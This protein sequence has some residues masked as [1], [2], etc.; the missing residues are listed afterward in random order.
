MK[1]QVCNRNNPF[2]KGRS[3][4]QFSFNFDAAWDVQNTQ[5]KCD[6]L[7]KPNSA[8]LPAKLA[9]VIF[10]ATQKLYHESDDN[11]IDFINRNPLFVTRKRKN[12]EVGLA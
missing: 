4:L 2:V 1:P 7:F 3:Y 9:V 8:A 10:R 12:E 11:T 6:S 5:N